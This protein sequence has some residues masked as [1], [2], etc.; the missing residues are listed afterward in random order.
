MSKKEHYYYNDLVDVIAEDMTPVKALKIKRML[1]DIYSYR[2]GITVLVGVLTVGILALFCAGAV[3]LSEY[4][5]PP[6]EPMDWEQFGFLFM[7]LGCGVGMGAMLA[8]DD[9][10]GRFRR[11]VVKIVEDAVEDTIEGDN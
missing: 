6:A 9:M 1:A 7:G 8:L 4:L 5:H 10:I 2:M 3:V 11:R